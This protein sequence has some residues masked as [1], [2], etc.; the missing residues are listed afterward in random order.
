MMLEAIN[1][2]HIEIIQEGIACTCL[3][4]QVAVRWGRGAE[5]A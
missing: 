2:P 5:T 4:H 1:D 3:S